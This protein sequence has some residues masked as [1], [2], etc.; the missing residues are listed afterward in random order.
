MTQRSRSSL[1]AALVLT[2]A[3]A[4]PLAFAAPA[5]PTDT[6]P[7]ASVDA[8]ANANANAATP[9][10]P[11]DPTTDPATPATPAVPAN[12]MPNVKKSWSEVD[13]D[14]DGKLT[15]AEAAAVPALSQVFDQADSNADGA[16]TADEYKNFVAKAK[17]GGGAPKSAP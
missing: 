9:A 17:A 2:T 3:A 16:L 7:P 12:G 15:K 4:M 10:T 14:K 11:A 6:K 8:A 5:K 1:L 13:G